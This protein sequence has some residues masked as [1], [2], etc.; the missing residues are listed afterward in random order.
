MEIKQT[1]VTLRTGHV[2]VFK[3]FFHDDDPELT[4]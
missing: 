4:N 3:C 1:I 2:W